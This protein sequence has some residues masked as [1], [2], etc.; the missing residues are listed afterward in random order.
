MRRFGMQR[1]ADWYTITDISNERTVFETSVIVSRYSV[2]CELS[3]I[4]D[5]FMTQ[6]LL[7][8]IFYD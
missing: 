7:V 8:D 3:D 6:K 5:P 1:R 2:S 4:H